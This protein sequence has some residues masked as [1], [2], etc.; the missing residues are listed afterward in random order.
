MWLMGQ[1]GWPPGLARLPP[2]P[3][4]PRAACL[5]SDP[6]V[7]HPTR[8]ENAAAAK[9]ICEACPEILECRSYAL[10]VPVYGI[11]GGTTFRER[12]RLRHSVVGMSALDDVA[13]PD[14]VELQTVELELAE[15]STNGN[16]H[17]QA[18][19]LKSGGEK[20]E[21]PLSDNNGLD[22]LSPSGG[23]LSPRNFTTPVLTCTQCDRPAVS[24]RP[25]CGRGECVNAHRRA[26]K[27]TRYSVNGR[28][29]VHTKSVSVN[30]GPVDTKSVSVD[31]VDSKPVSVD[32][33]S[34]AG[35]VP[36]PEIAHGLSDLGVVPPAPSAGNVSDLSGV[37]A[38]MAGVLSAATCIAVDGDGWRLTLSRST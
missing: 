31:K 21:K 34:A 14:E 25:T 18:E 9:A 26:T 23:E 20:T 12:Q 17:S 22:R 28:S 35:V 1:C 11:W 10:A 29:L 13:E 38:S 6:N 3:N 19:Q 30:Q 36:R 33:G 32:L 8:G 16:G 7:F 27:R 15:G 2:P 4:L 37:L 24:G 5:G